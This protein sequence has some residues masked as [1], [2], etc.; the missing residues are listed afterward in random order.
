MAVNRRL[1]LGVS[2][3]RAVARGDS[4][5]TL[6]GFSDARLGL[7][8]R[9]TLGQSSYVLSLGVN[10]PSGKDE[11]TDAE[12]RTSYVLSQDYLRFQVP[13]FGQGFNL[14]PGLTLAFPLSDRLVVG[15]GMTYQVLGSYRPASSL[16]SDYDPGNELLL[17]GGLDYRLTPETSFSADLTYTLYGVD[18]LGEEEV[19]AAGNKVVLSAQLRR[20]TGFDEI[21]LFGRYRTRAKNEVA[22]AGLLIEETAKTLP[23]QADLMGYYRFRLAPRVQLSLLAEARF[24]EATPFREAATIGGAG[25]APAFALSDGMEVPLRL[26][27]SFGGLTG[28][29]VACGLTLHF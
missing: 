11:L 4:V 3:S 24:V 1:R 17:T 22:L 10:V 16:L 2:A 6:S 13:H 18:T 15:A 19:F 27:Y 20:R 28:L 29:E 23:N 21:W 25:V 26:L 12:F 5:A 9:G 8:Y 7:N 14:S